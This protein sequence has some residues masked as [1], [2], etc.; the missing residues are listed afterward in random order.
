MIEPALS[1][2]KD[3]GM[4]EAALCRLDEAILADITAEHYDGAAYIVA[5]RGKVVRHK[6]VGSTDLASGRAAALDDR[7]C[8]MS[9]SKSLTAAKILQ[10][11]DRGALSLATPIAR[12][13]PEFGGKGKDHVTIFHALTHTGGI[14]SGFS[15]PSPLTMA[16]AM[17]LETFVP[18]ICNM[19]LAYE[20]GSQVTYIPFASFS[21]LGEVIAR[22][23]R[24]GRG[25]RRILRE[26]LFEP[27][28]MVDTTYGIPVDEPRRVPM[29]QREA[30]PGGLADRHLLASFNTLIDE[31]TELPGAG[32]YGTAADVLRFAEML[33]QGG[34]IDGTRFLSPA[35]VSF[36]LRNH[37]GSMRNTAWDYS[38][39]MR[40]IAEFPA[41]FALMG[42]Y[43]RGEGF[44][45]SAAGSMASANS[46]AGLGGGSTMFLID[47][48]RELT[49]VFLSAGLL[50]GLNHFV[51]SGRI[52]DLAIAAV[53]D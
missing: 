17:R 43:M 27:L 13:I 24:E 19:P 10:L 48:V 30:G 50:E 2:A 9:L 11:V 21:V 49:V 5:R 47:P 35:I 46:F 15:P 14:W 45:L 25:F 22:L 42:G 38:R 8:F 53:D 16:D 29:V 37:S 52:A 7:Y 6:S 28:G 20:L 32:A 44:F 4:D 51:R 40:G 3:A 26:D 31:N 1:S 12:I 39:Q 23:D 34:S 41:N 33:R 36:A 18:A